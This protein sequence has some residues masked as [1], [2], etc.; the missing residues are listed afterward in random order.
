MFRRNEK[1]GRCANTYRAGSITRGS[2]GMSKSTTT[3]AKSKVRRKLQKPK[4]PT[5]EEMQAVVRAWLAANHPKAEHVTVT[6]WDW[7]GSGDDLADVVGPPPDKSW[8]TNQILQTA[9][10]RKAQ[11]AEVARIRSSA[12]KELA[13]E[14]AILAKA[15]EI[16]PQR[17]T[18][19]W[20]ARWVNGVAILNFLSVEFQ[21]L[22]R[23]A[24][25][26]SAARLHTDHKQLSK[27]SHAV[28]AATDA[29][30][31]PPFEGRVLLRWQK[32]GAE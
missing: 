11:L 21:E 29:A 12:K 3:K 26:G 31:N 2:E 32:D 30:I 16:D 22:S 24:A 13:R 6:Q 1:P 7:G 5:L 9:A 28:L 19:E 14:A 8:H 25:R 18:V 15:D 20:L 23:D 10:E 4:P 27:V 17:R